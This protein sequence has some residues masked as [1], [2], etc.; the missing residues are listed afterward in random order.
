VQSTVEEVRQ[1]IQAAEQR[2]QE[3]S[4]KKSANGF[5]DVPIEQ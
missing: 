1:L 2:Q 3:A 5:V 4:T